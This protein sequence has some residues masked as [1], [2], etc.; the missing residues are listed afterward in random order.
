MMYP[1]T[2]FELNVCNPYSDNERK[3]KI[4]IFFQVQEGYNSGQNS[5]DY[6]QIWTWP[7]HFYDIPMYTVLQSEPLYKHQN[8]S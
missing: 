8:K 4:F 2:K 1:Y 7:V 6:D 5:T 3:L